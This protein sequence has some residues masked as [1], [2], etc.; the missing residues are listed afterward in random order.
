[1]H[2]VAVAETYE[3]LAIIN[4]VLCH[5]IRVAHLQVWK[6]VR[7]T[8]W[9]AREFDG[10]RLQYMAINGWGGRG[11]KKVNANLLSTHEQSY[12]CKSLILAQEAPTKLND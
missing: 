2:T 4:G 10:A 7:H 3:V 11:G 5:R 8:G 1:M 9:T 6:E 12:T